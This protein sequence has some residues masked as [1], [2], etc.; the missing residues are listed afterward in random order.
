[1]TPNPSPQ[2]QLSAAYA[3]A[4]SRSRTSLSGYLD[5]VVIDSRPEPRLFVDVARP[6]QVER[7]VRLGGPLEAVMGFRPP[8]EGPRCFWETMPRGYDKTTGIGRLCN[9]LLAFSKRP[10]EIDAAAGDEEQA[11][12]LKESMERESHLN[13]WLRNRLKFGTKRVYGTETGSVLKVL[14]A[15]AFSSFGLRPDVIVI[16]EITHWKKRDL[17]DALWSAYPKMPG[18]VVFVIT[19][20]GLLGSWQ[21]DLKEDAIQDTKTWVVF[22]AP[23]HRSPSRLPTWMRDEDIEA[24]RRKLPPA[25]GRRVYDNEWIDPAEE[26]GYLTRAEV[27]A[28]ED[29]GRQLSLAFQVEGTQTNEYILSIDY[30][31]KRDRTALAVLHQREDG[32]VV[33][34]RLEVW[35]G[36]NYPS[37]EVPLADVRQWIEEAR[38]D[39]GTVR[40][41]FDPHEML[42][43]AQYYEYHLPVHRY[44]ARGGKGNYTMAE[45][46]RSGI[47]NKQV[48]WYPGAG[49]VVVDGKQE[50]LTDEL[51]GL[52]LRPMPY[53]YRFDHTSTKHDDRAVVLGMALVVILHQLLPSRMGK[54]PKVKTP[55][56]TEF[57]YVPGVKIRRERGTS[58]RGLYGMQ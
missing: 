33:V 11:H 26:S 58:F 32:L 23:G 20:A 22:E 24:A 46:L 9:W 21:Y 34:D 41:V 25:E 8:W 42:D 4:G 30:G 2:E 49:T 18:C 43:I 27:M 52:V 50:T 17:W 6:W 13:P 31:P 35:E 5:S 47:V 54:V 40:L 36:K 15:D 55:Q 51:V 19:N 57:E 53:G 38:K 39:F 29:L 1:M 28:C 44:E 45:V 56:D 48:A 14:T 37:G 3:L 7:H 16:D 10:L 12:L